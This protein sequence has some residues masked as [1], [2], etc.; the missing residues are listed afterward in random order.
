[1]RNGNRRACVRVRVGGGVVCVGGGGRVKDRCLL[2][3]G[4]CRSVKM[5]KRVGFFLLLLFFFLLFF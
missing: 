5:L 2:C 1:M 4:M 3:V